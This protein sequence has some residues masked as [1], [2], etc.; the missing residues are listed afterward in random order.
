MVNFYKLDEDD[1]YTGCDEAEA[2]YV[3]IPLAEYYGYEKAV[4]IVKDR[5]IQQVD[6]ATAD[7]YGYTLMRADKKRYNYEQDEKAWLITRNTP[8]SIKIGLE[9]AEYFII[10]YSYKFRYD[11]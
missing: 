2:E 9:E 8:Y 5:A 1:C 6:K 10:I 3:M 4:R 7:K 11:F